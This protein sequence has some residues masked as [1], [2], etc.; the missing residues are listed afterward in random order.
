MSFLK[1]LLKRLAQLALVLLLLLAGLWTASR[2]LYPTEAQRV[3][4][5]EMERWPE[6]EGENAFPLLWTLGRDVPD[7][8]LERVLAE[9]VPRVARH[10]EQ[11]WEGVESGSTPDAKTLPSAADAYPD[12]A[13]DSGD[14][15]L[16]C[17]GHGVDCLPLVRKD[18]EAYTALIDRHGRLLDRVEEL[19]RH[20]YIRSP[21]PADLTTPWPSYGLTS[22]PRTRNAVR[23]ANG[24]TRAAVAAT[25]RDLLTWRRLGP[26]SDGLIP[27]IT[28]I[29]VGA[30]DGGRLL[31]AMLAELP[32]DEPLPE[33]CGD[34]L[35]PPSD[36]ELS[37]CGALRGEYALNA[38]MSRRQVAQQEDGGVLERWEGALLT[39]P[40]ASLGMVAEAYLTLC[41]APESDEGFTRRLEQL[42]DELGNLWRLECVANAFECVLIGLGA[43]A[44]A[45]Y[46]KRVMD[47]GARV[48]A[49]ATLAWMRGQAGPEKSPTDLLES[50]PAELNVAEDGMGFGPEGKTLQ[51]QLRWTRRGETW[52]IPLPPAFHEEA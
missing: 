39:D 51:I 32:V 46:M 16:F 21:F 42:K 10:N 5:A 50:R 11:Y 44:H 24:E 27:R 1:T 22:L 17:G 37:L 3:A 9:D 47:D 49:L 35:A 43:P 25:C 38:S 8:Q 14:R 26:R 30:R 23:F 2:M 19:H 40:A 36:A 41:P 15:Q 34:A 48:R 28:A 13:P 45:D 7:D 33:P 18:L 12:L 29:Q 6:Y 4:M 52:S 31:A 20:G